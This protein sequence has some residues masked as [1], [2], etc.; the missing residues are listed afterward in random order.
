MTYREL[1]ELYREGKLEEEKKKEVEADIERQDAISEYLFREADIPELTDLEPE[2]TENEDTD[3]SETEQK[4]IKMIRQSIRRAFVKMGVTVGAVVM[5][6][7]LFIVFL[8]PHLV[9]AFYYDPGKVV[10]RG[11]Y[12]QTNQMSLDMAVYSELFLPGYYRD[13]V[14]V[15]SRGYGNYDICI[16]QT[17]SLNG[18]FTNVSGKVE[19]GRMI[20]YDTNTLSAPAGNVFV[21]NRGYS[22]YIDGETGECIGAS[23][24]VQEAKDRLRELND[25]EEYVAYITLDQPMDYETLKQWEDDL[26]SKLGMLWYAVGTEDEYGDYITWD[27][28]FSQQENG[29][30][31]N[32]DE[33]KYPYLRRLDENGEQP[34]DE[35]SMTKHMISMLRYM[36][37]Q[38]EFKKMMMVDNIDFDQIADDIEEQGIR[39]YGIAGVT[40]KE[41]LLDL[42]EQDG[43]YYIHTEPLR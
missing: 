9:S 27:F 41:T 28:G 4:F 21:G 42:S 31:L 15:D 40:D 19:K 11:E 32:Y 20:L 36:D 38:T 24:T 14:T 22:K 12:T 35:E 10:A 13:N 29:S 8:L 34:E 2:L 16:Y 43:V 6:V 39:I 23:G 26:E 33:E 1:L 3:E 18:Q 25:D 17:V 7:V 5:A 30:I 37:A